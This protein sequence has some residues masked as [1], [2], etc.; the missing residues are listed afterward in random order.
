VVSLLEYHEH[1]ASVSVSSH[2]VVLGRE[3]GLELEA[4]V[5]E[6]LID[7]GEDPV[8][9]VLGHIGRYILEHYIQRVESYSC[10]TYE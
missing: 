8:L 5:G 4:V 10:V 9:A 3:Y 7:L 6:V 1:P 2:L